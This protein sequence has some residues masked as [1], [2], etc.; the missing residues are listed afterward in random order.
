MKHDG[1]NASMEENE[2]ILKMTFKI[3]DHR[4]QTTDM[5]IID[6][7]VDELEI[8][9]DRKQGLKCEPDVR[10]GEKAISNMK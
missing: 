7:Q 1:R 5:T 6:E 9:Y 4:Q 2:N 10:E 8:Y 3:C